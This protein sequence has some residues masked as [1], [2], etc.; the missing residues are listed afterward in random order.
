MKLTDAKTGS[1]VA[2]PALPE[3][4]DDQHEARSLGIA[5]GRPIRVIR[6]APMWGPLL[7]DVGGQT[8][9]LRWR[10]AS[11]LEVEPVLSL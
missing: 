11:H 5:P 10:T 3:D 6:R 8:K 2:V 4:G 9:A 7:L 1:W